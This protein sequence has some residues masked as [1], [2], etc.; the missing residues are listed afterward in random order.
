MPDARPS[1]IRFCRVALCFR[2]ARRAVAACFFFLAL[3]VPMPAW[4]QEQALSWEDLAGAASDWARENLDEDL[5]A[6]LEGD[7]KERAQA[8]F[9]R[10]QEEFTGPYVPDLAALKEVARL[11][12][13]VLQAHPETE[14]YAVWLSTRLDYFDVAEDLRGPVQPPDVA[15][16]APPVNPSAPKQREA[17]VRK[18]AKRPW[19]PRASEFVT[20]LKPIFAAEKVPPE[21]VWIAE[22][23]S[24]FDPRARSPVGAVG[25]FQL[26]PAT[27]KRFGLR[28]APFDQRTHPG[29]S[30][31]AAARYLNFLHG[32]FKDWRLA[33]A[34]YNCGEGT[35]QKLL[36]RHQADNF[37]QIARHL[38]AETQLYVPK[39]EATLLNREGKK[40]TAL[41]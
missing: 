9:R 3:A 32:R 33:A 2:S 37:D 21:L 4:C 5:L 11:L 22:V 29:D 26:M 12:V 14:P 38:P 17:W 25:L 7:D 16:L 34:A 15:P 10:V 1:L 20:R 35:V 8:F 30:A 40:L 6:A 19:P 27:A 39:L 31:R 18:T 24:S 36:A 28:T 23:E 13:P 41:R